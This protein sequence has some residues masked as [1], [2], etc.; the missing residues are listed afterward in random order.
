MAKK[1]PP[2]FNVRFWGVRGSIP[3]P[4]PTTREFGGNT[5]CVEV[6]SGNDIC[7]IDAGT[8]IREFGIELQKTR[9][10]KKVHLFITHTHWD[11]IQGLPFFTP[12]YR[13]D[14]EIEV[15]GPRP[16]DGSLEDCVLNQQLQYKFFPV[17]GVEIG[18]KVTFHE[19]EQEAVKIG[20]IE[21]TTKPMNHP[22]RVLAYRVA[23]RGKSVIYTGDNEPYYDLFV[24][25]AKIPD[26]QFIA[27]SQF[28]KQCQDN[29]IDFIRDTDLLIADAQYTDDE[30]S[31]KRGWGHSSVSHVLDMALAGS[32]KQVALFH[33]EPTHDDAFLRKMERDAQTRIGKKK[34]RPK[35]FMARE[36]EVLSI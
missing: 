15:Y 20:D 9:T 2:T 19:L 6:T 17:R 8:G 25:A 32:A 16:L 23:C 22:I 1:S 14:F 28:I 29:V 13:P 33:H 7:I 4:G 12:I 11:H 18:A 26:T 34:G 21:V 30:Y 10:V 35:I 24:D 27:R 36:G 3:C 31:T 5:S